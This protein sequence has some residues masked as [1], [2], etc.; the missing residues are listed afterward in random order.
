MENQYLNGLHS[1][2]DPNVSSYTKE[3]EK[4]EIPYKRACGG[5][6]VRIGYAIL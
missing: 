5:H 4:K 6:R 3:K 1:A 2:K